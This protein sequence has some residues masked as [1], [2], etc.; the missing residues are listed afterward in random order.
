MSFNQKKRKL[1]GFPAL[2]YGHNILEQG[3]DLVL[4]EHRLESLSYKCFISLARPICRGAFPTQVPLLHTTPLC[5]A[6]CLLPSSEP[7]TLFCCSARGRV[8]AHQGRGDRSVLH[9]LPASTT[10]G[11][12]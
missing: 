12:V 3:L 9:P 7:G 10:S 4:L 11:V 2:N 1:Q 8:C 5:D 6:T